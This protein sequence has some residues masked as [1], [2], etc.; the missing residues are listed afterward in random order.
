MRHQ[1][2]SKKHPKATHG[3]SLA[4]TVGYCK[5]QLISKHPYLLWEV[6]AGYTSFTADTEE[7]LVSFR[8][9]L[10]Q[11]ERDAGKVTVVEQ[12]SDAR[13]RSPF[14]NLFSWIERAAGIP[15][16]DIVELAALPTAQ[17][18]LYQTLR[19][20]CEGYFG[21]LQPLVGSTNYD[22]RCLLASDVV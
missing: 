5:A 14:M 16:M 4:Q 12:P 9:E 7:Y 17:D 3:L 6:A 8:E 13:H 10:K 1:H 21:R 15:V 19:A 11:F 2:F 22:I 20:T 18:R